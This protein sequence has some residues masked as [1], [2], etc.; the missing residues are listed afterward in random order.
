[1]R[2]GER[3]SIQD[4]VPEEPAEAV[5]EAL[6]PRKRQRDRSW[7][8]RQRRAGNVVTYRGVPEALHEEIKE[9]AEDL[10]VP[11]GDV[12]RA[13][14]EHGLAE[15]RSGGLDLSPEA[16]AVRRTLYPST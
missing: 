10:A 12:A 9:I 13:F 16:E 3:R 4:S 11:V 6:R 5:P 1:M 14:L 2:D 15:Y 8:R 7:E